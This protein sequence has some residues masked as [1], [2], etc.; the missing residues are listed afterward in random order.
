MLGLATVAIGIVLLAGGI[1]WNGLLGIEDQNLSRA[2]VPYLAA[3]ISLGCASL[4]AN[5]GARLASGLQRNWLIGASQ[6]L[7][8]IVNL[9][10][11]AVCATTGAPAVALLAGTLAVPVAINAV[12][13]VVLWRQLPPATPMAGAPVPI[14]QWWRDGVTFFIPQ[15][16]ASL[17]ANL[18]P[19]IIA[20]AL[21]AAAVTPYNLIQR[22]LNF[23]AQPQGWWLEPLWPAYADATSRGDYAWITRALRLSLAASAAFSLLPVVSMLGWGP[24]FLQWWAD[25]PAAAL[26]PGLLLWLVV[27]QAALALTQPLTLCLNGLGQ[28]RGQ[29]IYGT[30]ATAVSLIGMVIVTKKF[31]L[32]LAIAPMA[33]AMGALN[34]PCACLD[35]RYQLKHLTA[36]RA[37]FQTS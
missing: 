11:V 23:I 28:L 27:H 36:S 17:R 16:C 24:R 4:P 2:T 15:L 29:M 1:F 14:S 31:G 21:G 6:A 35:V 20:S 8:S 7:A 32:E 25:Y 26:S 19:F 18:P 30:A 37:A 9:L 33:F 3:L 5:L 10:V 34:L 12:L 22:L 13:L